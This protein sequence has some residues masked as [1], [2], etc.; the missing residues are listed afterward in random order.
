MTSPPADTEPIQ[1]FADRV[2]VYPKAVSGPVRRV[3]WAILTLCL[4]IY[5]LLPWVRYPRGPGMPN[6]AVLLDLGSRRFYFFGLEVWPQ[7]IYLLTGLLIL[8]AIGLFLVTSLAGRVWCGYACPQTVWTDLFLW[9][10]RQI[11]GDRA[12]RMKRD[13][14]PWTLDK[15]WRKA[16][17]HTAWL[18]VAAA[19]GGAWIMYYVDAPTFVREAL[20]GAASLEA[21]FFAAL[22]TAT[23]YL[24]AGWAREQVCTYMCPWPRFQS[25]MFDEQTITVTYQAR[26]GEPRS[27]HVKRTDAG[28]R[29][30]CID[31]G[32]CVVV[33]PTG[34]DIRDGIQLGCIG[35]GLCVDAC[36]EVMTKIGRPRWLINWDNL[37]G[38]AARAA[39]LTPRY[40]LV[41][42]RTLIYAAVLAIA[43]TG[44]VTA[45]LLRSDLTLAVQRDRA[46]L[47]VRLADGAIRNGYTLKVVNKRHGAEEFE[48]TTD[49]LPGALLID[50]EAGPTA[51]PALPV[52]VKA[53]TVATVRAFVRAPAGAASRPLRF[54]LR[55]PGSPTEVET[56]T[57]FLGPAP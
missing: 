50:P 26:R 21:Y 53:D 28:D 11:Q 15:L 39:G 6:Q 57:V 34:V 46:P 33:C 23:T 14:G 5:Y 54:I 9:V 8:A 31:C 16:A 7:E 36:N 19:T 22:F 52:S 30:D 29:G 1:F 13:A 51:A 47:F 27:R 32:Q 56:A 45:L 37:A 55:A 40:R 12:Q 20:I 24:L 48:L 42:P 18:L 44:V 17:T 43:G 38:Q 2:K 10:E 4:A 49:G 3:K 35:C 41:R 25:A